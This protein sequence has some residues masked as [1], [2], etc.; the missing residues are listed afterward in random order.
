VHLPTLSQRGNSSEA[1]G[2]PN[3]FASVLDISQKLRGSTSMS[4]LMESFCFRAVAADISRLVAKHG[5]ASLEHFGIDPGAF[6]A[7]EAE[8]LLRFRTTDTLRNRIA[9]AARERSGRLRSKG[10]LPSETEGGE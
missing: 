2:A 4:R 1:A 10:V 3:H 8:Y 7:Q 6:T 5:Q 9:E